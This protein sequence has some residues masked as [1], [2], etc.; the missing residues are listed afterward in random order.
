MS[1]TIYKFVGF[2]CGWKIISKH[3]LK[4]SPPF[5]FN[6][7]FD[8][9]EQ[10]IK[11]D[12]TDEFVA[13]MLDKGLYKREPDEENMSVSE[14]K[15]K[16]SSENTI[17]FENPL[18]RGV[19]ESIKKNIWISCFSRTWSNII[20]W[21]HY[22]DDH[23]GFCIGFDAYEL[24]TYFGNKLRTMLY[25]KDFT[26]I[27]YCQDEKAALDNMFSTKFIEW[28]YEEE[29][30]LILPKSGKVGDYKF[31]TSDDG[32]FDIPSNLIR[33]VF[34]GVNNQ[35]SRDEIRNEVGE[36]GRH[37]VKIN[38]LKKSNSAFSLDVE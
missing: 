28:S 20:M 29:E 17:S 2:E 32:I 8:T 25:S 31:L 18:L 10:L 37:R 36:I 11:F 33:Q 15:S 7:P 6:D 34:I 35:I 1:T 24:Q 3:K 38:K 30:R 14:L 23:K 21:S 4:F 12:L 13:K 9:Y 16:F 22:A 5:S 19:F 26:R 27:D